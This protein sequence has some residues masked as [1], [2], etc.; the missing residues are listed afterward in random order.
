MNYRLA[1]EAVSP[2]GMHWLL[3]AGERDWRSRCTARHVTSRH[4]HGH[5][6]TSRQQSEGEK[7]Q[8]YNIIGQC[9]A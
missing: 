9:R 1:I 7:V 4:G 8:V 3:L 5:G 6:H 2:K